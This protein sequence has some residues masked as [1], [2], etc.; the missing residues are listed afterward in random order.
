[1]QI[2]LKDYVNKIVRVLFVLC[3]VFVFSSIAVSMLQS[4]APVGRRLHQTM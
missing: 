4:V 2:L 3:L 1:M